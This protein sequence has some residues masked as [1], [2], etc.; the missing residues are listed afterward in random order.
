MPYTI[1]PTMPLSMAAGLKKTPNF[2]TS[3]QKTAAGITSAISLKPYPTW[4]FEFSLD[5]IQGQESAASS[6]LAQFI[7]TFM[8]TAGGANLF[9]F[10]DPQDNAVSAAQF[11]TG[12]GTTTAFQLSRTINGQVDV[13]QNLNGTPSIYVNG[14]PTTPSSIST[15]GVV[16]FSSAPTSG[17]V[18]TWTGSFYFLC[19]FAED[20]VD[21]TRSF[22][23]NSGIDQWNVEA[24]K[25]S[26][27]FVATSLTPGGGSSGSSGFSTN[28]VS[29]TANYSVL[30]TD[31][32]IL[33]N[34]SGGAFT[35]TLTVS[36]IPTGKVFTITKT[37]SSTNAVTL[38]P[39]S[40]TVDGQSSIALALQYMTV[41]VQFD[42][43]N[44]WI[45]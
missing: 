9:L 18:L 20:T 21:A 29:K 4:D 39:A 13:I 33:A 3:K 24:I 40:G 14:T 31:D 34:A 16:T 5:S 28:I 11:G 22:T 17:A 12:N 2:N 32:T 38:T 10:T 30:S 19:R 15:T 7:G 37:D 23:I 43:T 35:V 42:G 25:F 45:I 41:S 44:Y 36:G 1:M 26:S 6:V 8:A 27:E